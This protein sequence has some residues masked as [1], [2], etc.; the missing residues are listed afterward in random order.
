MFLPTTAEE[1]AQLGW[2]TLDII[3]VTGDAY[4]DSSFIG[5][6][7]I[8]KVLL[9]KGYKIGIIAQPDVKSGT[10]IMR[11][12][13]PALFWGVTA[14]AID[15]MVANYTA[16]KKR[17]KQ[18]DFTA[19]GSNIARPDR[20]SI[21][22]TNLIRKYFKNTKP[23]VLGG[24]EA[25]LRRIAHY[26]YWDNAIRRSILFDAKADILVYGMGEKATLELAEKLKNEKD[27]RDI[28]GICYIAP[29]CKNGFINLPSYEETKKDRQSFAGMFKLF[30]ENTDP[31]T[32]HGLCQKQDTRYL[33]QNP[34]AQHLT[35][36]E[37][38]NIYELDYERNVHPYYLDKGIVKAL[39]TI[40]FSITSHRGCY[41]ECNFCS[42][43]VHQGRTVISRS[44]DSIIREA[45][46]LIAAKDFKGYIT[47]IGGPTANM[48]GIECAQK[49]K[50]G[51]CRDKRCI[52]PD[53]CRAVD[54]SHK[55]QIALL[56]K[57]R[58]LKGIKKVFIGSG[59]RHDMVLEDKLCG[60]AYLEELI[61]HHISGQLKI[62]PE[63]VTPYV[64]D[65]MGK[66]NKEY[67]QRF[68]ELFNKLNKQSGKNQFLTYYFIA[69]HPGCRY[70]DMEELR[71]FIRKEI[72]INIEQVQI[73]TP[74][75]STYSALMYYTGQNPFNRRQLIVEKDLRGKETQ[76][77]L[78]VAG[79]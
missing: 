52:Y 16:L 62:A 28:R 74:L 55:R 43:T 20:A 49:M 68:K 27:Y 17:K 61:N 29:E 53:Y 23:I 24:V 33:I 65:C 44:E 10:D 48:Y 12:G 40:K 38:D 79:E 50:S 22:Y 30:Y 77:F 35:I 13:E 19:G 2:N 11:L 31:I 73:F 76:K 9:D 51:A 59:I 42:I 18:D 63:H 54:I 21:V 6:S 45:K 78:V 3:L 67:L 58:R 32:A 70:Q 75:P 8:G 69:A 47:D 25:S 14:G 60:M 1:I 4:L 7:V 57:L 15:S 36:S 34:P 66:P 56:G 5:V 37:L 71:D 72:R 46:K 41:G 39:D 64:L 26:D